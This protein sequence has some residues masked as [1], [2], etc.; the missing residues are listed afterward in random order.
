MSTNNYRFKVGTFECIAIADGT[1]TYSASNLFVNAP[2]EHLEQMLRQY[3]LQP[4]KIV[5]PYTCLGINTG[6]HWV[7]VD[8]G[9]GAGIVPTAGKLLQSLQAEGIGPKDID[10]VILT[11]GHGD[12]IGGNTDG[13]GKPTFPNAHYIMWRDEWDFWTSEANLVQM[14][15]EEE[16][17]FVRI[18]LLPI[19]DQLDLIDREMEILPGIQAIPTPGHTPGH[20]VLAISS[21]SEKLL[22]ISDA[23]VHPIHLEQPDWY[24]LYDLMPEQAMT[25]RRRLLDRAAA[26]RTLVFAFHFPFPGLG[27]VIPKGESWQWQPVETTS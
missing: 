17:P 25:T 3:D 27:H 12:H 16:I 20:M 6:E 7:L 5:I 13:E 2:K 4:E 14:Q 22:Y 10:T 24:M 1:N 19:Q 23:V 21:G 9:L 11:H 15:M 26:G 18:K 8:T